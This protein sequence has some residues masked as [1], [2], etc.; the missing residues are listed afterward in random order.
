MVVCT[1]QL[2]TTTHLTANCAPP[3]QF[4]MLKIKGG[5]NSNSISHQDR[6]LF[7]PGGAYRR[8]TGLS[9]TSSASARAFCEAI[10]RPR[11]L[12]VCA[13]NRDIVMISSPVHR[14]S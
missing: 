6:V 5:R 2:A 8:Y 1:H 7:G 3:Q 9:T 14:H 12:P 4:S 13:G 10:E 11:F